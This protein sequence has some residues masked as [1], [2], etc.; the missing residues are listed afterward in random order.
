MTA[1]LARPGEAAL[2]LRVDG[3]RVVPGP[4][5]VD[6]CLVSVTAPEAPPGDYS[7]R[8]VLRDSDTGRSA[9]AETAVSLRR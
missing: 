3:V 4:D 6:R 5:G 8:L 7:L 9:R 2:P 1:E